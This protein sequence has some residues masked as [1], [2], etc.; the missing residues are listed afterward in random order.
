MIV[1]AENVFAM[2][3]DVSPVQHAV[4]FGGLIEDTFRLAEHF[5]S[6]DRGPLILPFMAESIVRLSN[7][8]CF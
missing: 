3:L 4:Q 6:I 8:H 7:F 1:M 2:A 5:A